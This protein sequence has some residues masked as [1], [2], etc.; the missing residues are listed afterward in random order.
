MARNFVE[1]CVNFFFHLFSFHGGS[2]LCCVSTK[3]VRVAFAFSRLLGYFPLLEFGFYCF[4]FVVVGRR[5]DDGVGV[6]FI[7]MMFYGYKL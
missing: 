2:V 5:G 3:A 7:D 1:S 6:V 4:L